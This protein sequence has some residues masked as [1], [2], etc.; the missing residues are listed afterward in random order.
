MASRLRRRKRSPWAVTLLLLFILIGLCCAVIRVYFR[1]P[2]QKSGDAVLI[3]RVNSPV[4]DQDL[5]DRKS[6]V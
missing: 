4:T 2:E 3:Q 5:R 1:A 6:V